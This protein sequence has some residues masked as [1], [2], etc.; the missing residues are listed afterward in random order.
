[1]NKVE[2]YDKEKM[3]EVIGCLEKAFMWSSSEE[4]FDYWD[5]VWCN[6][7]DIRDLMEKNVCPKCGEML[8]E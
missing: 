7:K 3:A 8:D 5:S 2:E 4:G 1:M 6:L